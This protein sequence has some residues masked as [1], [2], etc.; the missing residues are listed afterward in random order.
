M[1]IKTIATLI[2]DPEAELD[3]FEAALSLARRFSAHLTV[4]APGV[5]H[6]ESL[7]L[8]PD[9][10]AVIGNELRRTAEQDAAAVRARINARMAGEI[11]PWD[12]DD[13]LMSGAAVT[14]V[15]SETLRY[16]DLVVVPA[17]YGAAAGSPV[18]A[19][20]VEAALFSSRT[21]V[22]VIPDGG[23]APELGADVVVAWNESDEAMRAAR[24]A[25]PFMTGAAATRVVMFDPQRTGPERSDP[26]GRIASFLNRHGAR[27]EI[28]I[29][30]SGGKSTY[31]AL[32]RSL[33]EQGAGLLVMGAYGK[34]RLRE[35]IFGGTTR[36]MLEAP[37]VPVLMA[38]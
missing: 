3:A 26:G 29:Q 30:Q 21:P 10:P 14:T 35:A 2:F 27:A 25:L 12:L 15:L 13:R 4:I 23:T 9:A 24:A 16:A 11:V 5:I 22:M 31:D 37:P 33:G 18:M 8:T 20:A 6:T 34:T 17:P 36:D 32:G 7:Y 1:S 38:H 28:L 19:A